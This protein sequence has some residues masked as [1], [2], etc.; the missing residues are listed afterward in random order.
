MGKKG[1]R[2]GGGVNSP[3]VTPKAAAEPAA[4]DTSGMK[5]ASGACCGRA[6]GC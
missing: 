1:K 3:A 5:E 4:R 6:W 2:A